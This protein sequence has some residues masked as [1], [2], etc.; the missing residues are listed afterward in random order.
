MVDQVKKQA[1]ATVITEAD[2]LAREAKEGAAR[3]IIKGQWAAH[4]EMAGQ[5]HGLISKR[6][7]RKP[8]N[9]VAE[10]KLGEVYPDSTTYVL[11]GEPGH[12]HTQRIP[13]VS[14]VRE[15]RVDR[16]NPGLMYLTPD[17]AVEVLSPNEPSAQTLGKMAADYL[18]FGASQ[19]WA[20]DPEEQ[21]ITVYT[22]DSRA[23]I[24]T[25]THTLTADDLLPG[26]SLAVSYIF[27][28]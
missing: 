14:F 6:V 22:P 25:A 15:A 7:L 8:D 2:V 3:E 20:I 26:F 21:A 1:P 17:L 11:D 23:H 9:F 13:D 19:V 10:N 28:D 5:K 24:Y 12:I 16:D 4:S 27:N 18:R